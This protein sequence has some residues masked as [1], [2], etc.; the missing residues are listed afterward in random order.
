MKREILLMITFLLSIGIINA[1]DSK[2]GIKLLQYQRYNSAIENFKIV[3]NQDPSDPIA[4]FWLTE[5]YIKNKEADKAISFINA[6]TEALK[7][8]QLTKISKAHI[9]AVQNKKVEADKIL[10]IKLFSDT[11]TNFNEM[12]C[13]A[14]GRVY[15]DMQKYNMATA[16]FLRAYT[17][18]PSNPFTMVQLGQNSYKKS[19][20]AAA[21]KYFTK[22]LEIEP[23]YTTANFWLGKLYKS[24][25]NP[26][27]YLTYFNKV[28]A[29]D[30]LF[31]PAWYELY[32][33]AYYNDKTKIKYYYSK[34]LETADKTNK[35]EYQL[36]VL[37][38][39]NKKFV[40]VIKNGN[41][42]LADKEADL[43]VEIYK[44]LAY[45]YYSTKNNDQA[46]KNM[47]QY[48]GV[49]DSIKLTSFDNYLLAQ[50]AARLVKKD[51]VAINILAAEYLRDT[52]NK[53][54]YFYASKIY[55]HYLLANEAFNKNLWKERLLPFKNYDKVEMYKV[56]VNW[57]DLNELGKADTIFV[58]LLKKYP[59]A[60]ESN[61]MIGAI[62]AKL[63][64][65]YSEGLA[66][67]YFT[68]FLDS[69]VNQIG[70]NYKTQIAQ[71]YEYLGGYYL[72]KK[73]YINTLVYYQ[74]LLAEKPNDAK[75]KNTVYEIRKY[76]K[77]LKAYKKQKDK[78]SN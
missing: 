47:I 44:Y 61:Y 1:Q 8:N 58:E 62:R 37:D 46:Y 33:H 7:E 67:P 21:H 2:T 48:V 24:Q 27:L 39:N 14:L 57:Y 59:S 76:L 51:S 31:A 78:N 34:Y 3:L 68:K 53:N 60:H 30:S 66:L 55:N 15:T 36:L 77:D 65:N 49:Q 40:N 75:V 6:Q 54:K 42:M 35:Q 19:D 74:K 26:D 38:Y 23:S 20:G 17:L 56:G 45:S 29:K 41:A 50:F 13:V 5:A 52:S 73:D 28:I 10:S 18:N 71:V 63:D 43:P 69:T 12:Q 16:F 22:A 11:A 64:S 70:N 32:R 4:L 72:S 25:N 9:L